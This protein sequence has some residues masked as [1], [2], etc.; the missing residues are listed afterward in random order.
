MGGRSGI[1]SVGCPAS[2]PHARVIAAA[3]AGLVVFFSSP[4]SRGSLLACRCAISRGLP[5]LAYPV[6]FSS[7][8]LPL[9]GPGVWVSS[10]GYG[11][12]K[13]ASKQ[14]NIFL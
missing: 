12:F 4:G 5:V 1:G 11:G 9:T 2:G 8:E 14:E 3:D 6:G 10:G 7:S 13:W